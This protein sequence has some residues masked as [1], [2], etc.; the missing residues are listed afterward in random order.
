M[1]G[2][3][4]A[5]TDQSSLLATKVSPR[6]ANCSNLSTHRREFDRRV[7]NPV[8]RGLVSS[9]PHV[10]ATVDPLV[11]AAPSAPRRLLP[12]L[13]LALFCHLETTRILHSPLPWK[14]RSV[15]ERSWNERLSCPRFMCMSRRDVTSRTTGAS[16][17]MCVVILSS[18]SPSFLSL[19]LPLQKTLGFVNRNEYLTM[20]ER[21]SKSRIRTR[22]HTLCRSVRVRSM[23]SP[24]NRGLPAAGVNYAPPALVPELSRM[25]IS[26][27][28]TSW[29]RY[30]E[31][32][33]SDPAF[34]FNRSP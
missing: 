6:R 14:A 30:I 22:Q 16:S 24:R 3:N 1:N 34:V 2:P 26:T 4:D 25:V 20:N 11:A 31:G 7:Q 17:T 13:S 18:R 27:S 5:W 10:S 33:R 28:T 12:T 9:R 19:S 29:P 15:R 8:N 23:V 21:N 32:I